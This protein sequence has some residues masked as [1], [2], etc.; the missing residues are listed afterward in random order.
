MVLYGATTGR[1]GIGGVSVLAS[2]TLEEVGRGV[3]AERADRRPVRREAPDRSVARADRARTARGAAGPGRRGH[4]LRGERVG[5]PRG[6]GRAARS[7]RRAAARARTWRRSRSSPASRRSACSRSCTR[8]SSSRCARSANDGGLQI[9]VIAE[10]VEGGT[11]T[12]THGGRVVAEVPAVSLADEGPVYDRPRAPPDSLPGAADD[13][14]F[15]PFE[16]DL[17][18]GARSRAR[19]AQRRLEAVGMGAVRLARAG[20][21]RRRGRQRRRDRAPARHDEGAR[22]VHRRQGPIRRARS[23]PRC[24]AR[25]G[26]GRAQRGRDRG[27]AAR[28]HELHELRQ[29]GTAGGDVAVR[30][31]DPGHARRLPRARDA[32]DRRQRELLQRVGRFRDLAD[33]G[34]R[35]ARPA[36]RSSPAGADRLPSVRACRL[37]AGGDVPR[38]RWVG[39]RRGRARRGGRAPAGARP[40]RGTRAARP[41]GRGRRVRPARERAR[42]RRRRA[43]GRARRSRRSTAGTGSR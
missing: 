33:A 16:G 26:R 18:R 17:L 22:P 19:L 37:P 20:P 12:V 36:R 15:L 28:D 24:G 1:D 11:L 40:R 2:A 9:A 34:D 32:R 38:A 41:A 39:V 10:L 21:D 7:R 25:G 27:A 29:P 13:P 4:H 42:L 14:T 3:A 43:R 35:H 6:D 23:V 30:R 8:R 31:V 5:G